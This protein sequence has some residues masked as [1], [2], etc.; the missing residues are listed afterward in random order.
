[1]R[2]F[3]VTA[4]EMINVFSF[5]TFFVRLPLFATFFLRLNKNVTRSKTDESFEHLALLLRLVVRTTKTSTEFN[6]KKGFPGQK[7]TSF[8]SV[9]LGK[10]GGHFGF[11]ASML[12][13]G[14]AS[15][16]T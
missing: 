16:L 14:R 2:G 11:A 1:M 5:V 3:A 13:C 12:L 8:R 15:H 6:K 9:K 7:N 10:I 4:L